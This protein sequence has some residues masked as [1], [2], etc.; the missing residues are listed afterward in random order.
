MTNSLDALL[1]PR[2][3]AVVGA[4]PRAGVVGGEIL[5]NIVRGG[6]RGRVYPVNP[7]HKEIDGMHC[8]ASVKDIPGPV[9]LAIIAVKRNLAV[10]IAQDCG[11][12]NIPNLVVIT[13]GFKE[14]GESG[15]QLEAQLQE[16]AK[17]YNINLIGPNCMG[18]INSTP[19][20][21]L[22][23][24]FSRWFP[25]PGPI[26]FI[27]QSGSLGETFLE[28]F[29]RM[30]LGVSLFINLGNRAGLTENDLLIGLVDDPR[31]TTIFLYLES[32]ADPREL[33]RIV[34]RVGHKKRFLVL[35]AGRTHAGAAAAASH[36]GALATPDAIVDAFLRQSGIIRVFSI[37][38][39]LVALRAFSQPRV[40]RGHR[41][42][43]LTNAGGAGIIATDACERAGLEVP[44]FSPETQAE[45]ATFLPPEASIG[46][47]VDM[48]ATA[49]ADDYARALTTVLAQVDSALV[50]FRP[51]I[52]LP[53]PV[54]EVAA[55]VTRVAAQFPDKVIVACTLSESEFVTSFATHLTAAGVPVYTMPED[56]VAAL[57][58]LY[59]VG[60]ERAAAKPGPDTFQPDQ[61]SVAAIMEQARQAG[62]NTLSFTQGAKLLSAYG[63]PVAAYAYVDDAEFDAFV[64]AVGFPL[65]AKLD[66][67]G[68]LHRFER[69]AVVVGVQDRA[70]LDQAVAQLQAVAQ[71]ERLKKARV[72]VQPMIS[73]RE[74]IFG[75]KR[76]PAFG[77]VLMFG[78]GG[79][80]VEALHDVSFGV[81]PISPAQAEGMIRA[82]RA[83]PLLGAFRGQ[84]AID[85]QELAEFIHR[86]GRLSMDFSSIAEIDINPFIV[87][88]K[89]QGAVD[90]LVRLTT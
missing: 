15:A 70:A 25:K 66:A 78:I 47:P 60:R 90:I 36:T 57:S 65:A 48:I 51:P 1:A 75:M 7:R 19:E 43:I 82:I 22:N 6:Y 52:V 5:R 49:G 42:A 23:A 64:N 28:F 83:F 50:I 2:A 76:D 33:R 26:A 58:V 38:E 13:A 16:T 46:N 62:L 55:R 71:R 9:D 68:L 67:P 41:V 35:K 80:L 54:E 73:G 14:S 24:S 3:V 74:L 11:E 21:S 37:E 56:G 44:R 88:E 8:Y 72:L 10:N 87:G 89:T 45:L 86:L 18:I 85:T 69:G 53:D 79:T 39:T 61:D 59:R 30:G 81:A 17:Q 31:I 63:I 12:V 29:D 40:P 27:S 20:V 34:E 4:S 84:K 32:F 77:P